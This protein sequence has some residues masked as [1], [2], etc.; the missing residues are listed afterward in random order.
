VDSLK[1]RKRRFKRRSIPVGKVMSLKSSG[2]SL[3][4]KNIEPRDIPV[5]PRRIAQI[6]ICLKR[7]VS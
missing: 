5:T 4:V 7:W 2:A 3:S 6:Q 1:F